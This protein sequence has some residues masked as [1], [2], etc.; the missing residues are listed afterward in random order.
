MYR[1]LA[2]SIDIGYPSTFDLSP[3]RTRAIGFEMCSGPSPWDDAPDAGRPLGLGSSRYRFAAESSRIDALRYSS[4]V[5]A[6]A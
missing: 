4:S 2:Q 6:S 3:D 1:S 5:L